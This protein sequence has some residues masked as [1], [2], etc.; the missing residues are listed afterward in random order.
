MLLLAKNRIKIPTDL[1]GLEVIRYTD[2]NR[3]GRSLFEKALR[4]HLAVHANSNVSL[5]RAMVVPLEP[6]RSYIV[7]NPKKPKP[8]SRFQF[9]PR[10]LRTYGD[11]LG[12]SGVLGAFASTYGEHFPPEILSASHAPP[13][14]I[15]WDA[16]FYLVGS[17]KSNPFTSTFL[18]AMQRG[19]YPNWRLIPF[20]GEENKPDYEVQLCSDKSFTTTP[21]KST[22]PQT[23][24]TD[25]GLIVRGPHPRHTRRM[26]TIFAGPHSLGTGGACLAATK[27]Q[28][29][30]KISENLANRIDITNRDRTFWVLVKAVSSDDL[31]IDTDGVEIV[32]AGVYDEA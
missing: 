23:R 20:P 28:L 2:N 11:Y 8:D 1:L 13:E 4:G 26:V 21:L 19:R 12:V 10:E 14:L 7:I 29:I 25:Y 18:E 30:R 27:S 6:A 17:P 16:N 3:E 24:P 15:D 9:H 31:H 32:D 5:L 22:P